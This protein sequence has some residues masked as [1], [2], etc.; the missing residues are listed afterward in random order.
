MPN[1]GFVRV[2][3]ATPKMRVTDVRYNVAEMIKLCDKAAKENVQLL[4][5]PELAITGYTCGDLFFQRELLQAAKEGLLELG[6][7]TQAMPMLIVVGLPISTD[8]QLFNCA[9]VISKGKLLGV[10]PKTRIPGYK[11]FY[12]PRW[13]APARRVI[14]SEIEILGESVAFGADLL[15]KDVNNPH[16]IVGIEICEDLWMPIPPSSHMVLNGATVIG[17]LSASNEVVGKAEYRRPLVVQQSGRGIC[18][19]IYTSCGVYESTTDVVFSGHCMIAENG[20]LLAESELFRRDSYLTVADVDVER[21]VRER[22]MTNSFG[23]TIPDE[24]Q[25]FRP[26]YFSSDPLDFTLTK[27]KR[28]IAPQPFVPGDDA[29]RGQRCQVIF[30][31]QV[32]GL[33]K[34]I[35]HLHNNFGLEQAVIGISGGL[36][37]TLAL[38]VMVGAFDLISMSR[39]QIL[40][41][42]MPGFGTTARTKSNAIRLCESLGVTLREIPI[43]ETVMQHFKDIGHD[44]NIHNLTY[45]NAQARMRTMILMD[46]GFVIGTGDLSELALGWCTYNGDHMSM[47]GVNA[48]IPKTLVRHLVRWVADSKMDKTTQAILIDILDTPISPELLPPDASDKIVQKTEEI[49]GPYELI[50]FYVFHTL[51]NGYSPNKI[52]FL[53]KIAFADKYEPAA[54]LKWLEAFYIRFFGQQFKRSCLPDGPKVGSVSL[55]PRGDW[56]MPSDSVPSAWLEALRAI[57]LKDSN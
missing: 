49:V 3:C 15:F 12:E 47:Y 25:A 24:R 30:N 10:I 14:N 53:A 36:D 2:A 4:V 39:S 51:R 19:Y 8:N 42:T 16:F 29:Q 28:Y 41:V 9:A 1:Y 54:L 48:G 43:G 52:H 45:E 46:L 26:I 7:A 32:A 56:R 50:D 18:A 35:E 23:E 34:R 37:S 6:V 5:F 33:A 11:E 44:P 38:L 40:A 55:S 57:D 13:F 22:E 21:L 20:S 31:I 17:N 27:L